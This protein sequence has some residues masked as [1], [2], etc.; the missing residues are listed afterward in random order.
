LND[1]G[2]QG[3]KEKSHGSRGTLVILSG[4][5]GVGKSSIS[6]QLI[7][8][9]D[10]YFSV[11]MTTRPIGAGEVDGRDYWFVTREEFEKAL[12]NNEL[13]E[14]AEVFGNYY[15]TPRRPV[16]EALA[17]GRV[18]LLEIDVQGALQAQKQYPE[19]VS[20]FLLPPR[21]EELARRLEGRNRGEDAR[22]I[23]KRLDK[24]DEEI[25]AGFKHYDYQVVNDDLEKAIREVI[26]IIQGKNGEPI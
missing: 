14:H 11:S 3:V 12:R 17:A 15:G 6:R 5:S 16:E 2:A 26:N 23:K 18:A 19:A 24:A 20:I 13:I 8:R 21:R 7:R 22:T 9:L 25:A 10:A 1:R 4:P